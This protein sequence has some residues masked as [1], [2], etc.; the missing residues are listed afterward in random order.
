ML[1]HTKSI[2]SVHVFPLSL[3]ISLNLCAILYAALYLALD[4]SFIAV[5]IVTVGSTC[6]VCLD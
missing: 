1:F 2:I 5:N 3:Q 4:I 6:T